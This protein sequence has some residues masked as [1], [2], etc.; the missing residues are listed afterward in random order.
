MLEQ[1]T[2]FLMR[3]SNALNLS[4]AD[5]LAFCAMILGLF[6]WIRRVYLSEKEKPDN[7]GMACYLMATGTMAMSGTFFI[8]WFAF[9]SA[10]QSHP[11]MLGTATSWLNAAL[12]M[13]VASAIAMLCRAHILHKK[14]DNDLRIRTQAIMVSEA[15]H[16]EESLTEEN[17]GHDGT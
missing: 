11:E 8:L 10:A 1:A 5:T 13:L 3:F 17:R 12:M 6:C 9:A 14:A 16:L 15:E 2:L 4:I 7:V